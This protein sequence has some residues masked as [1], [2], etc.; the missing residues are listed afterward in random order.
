MV[1]A[2]LL[3][4]PQFQSLSSPLVGAVT[5]AGGWPAN[6][7]AYTPLAHEVARDV[8]QFIAQGGGTPV[9]SMQSAQ[10]QWLA[11]QVLKQRESADKN[12]AAKTAV[13]IPAAAAANSASTALAP[14]QQA[15][16]ARIAPWAQQA[17]QRLGVSVRSVMAHAA[18]ESGWGQRPVRSSDGSDSLNLFGIKAHAGWEGARATA[19]TTEFED[20]QPVAQSQDFRQYTGLDETFADYVRLLERSPRYRAALHTGDDVQAFAQALADGG[21]ATDPQ[22]AQKLLRVSRSIAPAP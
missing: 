5:A 3:A 18:L 11:M 8:Q 21:Y 9:A 22:Y 15:F 7:A 2:E 10:A 14:T 17:A 16:L 19:W 4:F 12:S 13:D 6:G 20:G 1:H